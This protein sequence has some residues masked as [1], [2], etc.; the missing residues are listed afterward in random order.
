MGATAEFPVLCCVAII[1][2]GGVMLLCGNS[3]ET[4]A[5]A[6][7]VNFFFYVSVVNCDS[8]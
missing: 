8:A 2:V 1:T 3:L 7:Y 5:D 6:D 4:Q